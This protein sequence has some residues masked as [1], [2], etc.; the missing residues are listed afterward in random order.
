[1]ATSARRLI[2]PQPPVDLDSIPLPTET[3]PS[4]VWYRIIDRTHR[5]GL[6]WSSQGKY[7]FDSPNARH[8]VC[9]A[10]GTITASFQEI[11]GDRARKQ[12]PIDWAE[13]TAADVWRLELPSTAKLLSL[14][15]PNLTAIRATLQ[16]FTSSY[17][18]SQN[19]GAALM[20]HP[21][22]LDGLLYI[23]RRCGSVCVAL[24]GDSSDPKPY[25]ARLMETRL[26]PLVQWKR[27]FPLRTRLRL[28]IARLPPVR[29]PDT[30][31]AP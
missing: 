19:W 2:A 24:F 15:G 6:F 5:S 12:S 14:T 3:A 25:Q 7:R 30:F 20:K 22:D 10:G 4:L 1:M 16:C 11:W 8:G 18:T 17:A 29:P 9:Y 23:G 26:G 21:A 28:R 31:D 13:F 27:F